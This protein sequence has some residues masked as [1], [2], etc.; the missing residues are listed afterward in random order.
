MR[1]KSRGGKEYF[2][3][4][5]ESF[6]SDF[7]QWTSTNEE[8]M[9]KGKTLIG[10]PLI[11]M[12]K[13]LKN[14]IEAPIPTDNKEIA[15]LYRSL[16]D[17]NRSLIDLDSLV[18]DYVVDLLNNIIRNAF[19]PQMQMMLEGKGLRLKEQPSDYNWV[20]SPYA[21]FRIINNEWKNFRIGIEF[22]QK[23]LDRPIIGFLKNKDVKRVDLDS[24]WNDLQDKYQIKRG[25]D[26]D[27]WIFKN[28]IGEMHW[29]SDKAINQIMDGT[30]VNQF[31]EMIDEIL[32]VAE[33]VKIINPNYE[34]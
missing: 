6:S 7:V 20:L 15:D 4:F 23:W 27:S 1:E 31:A 12:D 33:Q 26:N 30:I 14:L 25:K 16:R 3:S 5:A 22:E 32:N 9:R 19:C 29:H 28:F 17:K 10:S 24:L 13:D 21:G 2:C 11:L 18:S 8:G 34:L